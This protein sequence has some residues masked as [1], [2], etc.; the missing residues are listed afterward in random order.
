MKKY[1]DWFFE[2]HVL[3]HFKVEETYLFPVLGEEHEMV[4]RAL[5]EHRRLERLFREVKD[6]ERSLNRIEEELEKHVRFEERELFQ[7]IQEV[8]TEKQLAIVQENHKEEK[9]VE[10]TEDE[11][12][13]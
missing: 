4:K 5:A 6:I 2:N 10:N 7:K 9:F 11:F 13:K 1:S 3:P 12:W 8:A